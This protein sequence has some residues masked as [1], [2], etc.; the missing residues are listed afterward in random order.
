MSRSAPR[1]PLTAALIACLVLV[2]LAAPARAH[3]ER[4]SYWPDPAPDCSVSPCAGGKV[5]TA[6]TLASAL[7]PGARTHVVCQADSLERLRASIDKAL[8]VGYY[9]RPHDHRRFG[10]TEAD[11]L[12]KTNKAL[13]ARCSF[14]E[15]QPA[16][17]A[18]GN[19]DRVVVLPGVY[20]EPTARRALSHDP[21]CRQYELLSGAYSY[22]GEYKC[23]NDANL[24]AV[25]GRTPGSAKDP[26]PPLVD[27]HG[28]PNLGSCVRCNLQLEG[29]GVSADDV[30]IDAGRVASGNG[31]P[32]GSAK[33][34]GLRVDRADGFVLR[35]VNVRHANEH[36]IYVLE[37]DGYLLDRFKAFYSGEYGVLTFVEDHGLVQNCEA[38][39][40]GDSGLYPG[41]GAKTAAGRDTK[42]YPA[43]RY[44]QEIRYCDS[45]HNTSG[46]SGTNGS[47]THVDH[48]NFYG[49]A[50]GFTTDVFT[51]AGHPG[52]PQQG[53]LV[54]ANNFSSNNF[55]PYLPGSDVSPS[56]PVPV[57][58]GLWIAGGNDNV[59]RKNHFYDNWRR[60]PML[61][62]SPDAA[63]CGDRSD[64]TG[65][66]PLTVSTS[67]RN[68]LYGNVMGVSPTKA[69]APNGVDFW[70]DAFPGNTQNCWWGNT[71]APG[72]K[73]TSSPANLPDCLGG[74]AP[75]LSVGFGNVGNEAELLTCITQKTRAPGGPCPW[76]TTPSRPGGGKAAAPGTTAAANE[77]HQDGSLSHVDCLWWRT[78]SPARRRHML[79]VMRQVFGARIGSSDHAAAGATLT[80][81][82]A[83]TVFGNACTPAYA[84]AFKL[85]KL[86]NHAAA[87]MAK[88]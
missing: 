23:Q 77:N 64:I 8:R 49:N 48:N 12:W 81:Q 79:D 57:G 13:F 3:I 30:V 19:N 41:A 35:N 87:F 82:Q 39:G 85:Y 6:K 1:R 55:N 32:R 4:P 2:G 70:W 17:T 14:R 66:N 86:Y 28:I 58:T 45:H 53:D 36:G 11:T 67:Y 88:R 71:A 75:W 18:S 29:S 60:G 40:S 7:Q 20:T 63:V 72:K 37:T 38:A 42:W 47:A 83:T 51:A 59:V 34:V 56:V 25:M 62:S 31:G 76:Y 80:D 15:I 22:L 9:I 10:R 46:Y 74:R 44:S 54:E 5:P 73:V 26:D 33:D 21:A 69:V 43:F 16:V 24:I 50:L 27:R 78:A 84:T 65:C 68:K 61:F 52:F